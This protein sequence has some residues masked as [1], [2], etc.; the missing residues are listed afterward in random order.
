MQTCQSAATLSEGLKYSP[1]L[2]FDLRWLLTV[3]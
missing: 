1:R 3:F 2:I